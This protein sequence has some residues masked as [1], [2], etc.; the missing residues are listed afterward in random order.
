MTLVNW[1]NFNKSTEG[2]KNQGD[3]VKDDFV[4]DPFLTKT[5]TS[6]KFFSVH[7]E[8]LFPK[9]IFHIK[10]IPKFHKPLFCMRQFA[11]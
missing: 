4:P 1:E 8:D 3:L 9:D 6:L 10:R 11:A 5:N 7:L 2:K